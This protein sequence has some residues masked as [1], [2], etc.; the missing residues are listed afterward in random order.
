VNQRTWRRWSLWH[1]MIGLTVVIGSVVGLWTILVRPTHSTGLTALERKAQRLD[2]ICR[3][4]DTEIKIGQ[5]WSTDPDA[6][7][8]ARTTL[9]V[10][11]RLA[12][13][14]HWN[15]THPEAP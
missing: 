2:E 13:V 7:P 5:T 6:G 1:S 4:V 12:T 3:M 8:S 10:L 15:D 14:C 9:Q 11:G